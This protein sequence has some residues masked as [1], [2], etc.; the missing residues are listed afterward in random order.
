MSGD[1]LV[2]F[3]LELVSMEETAVSSHPHVAA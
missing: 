3:I 1:D 2:A